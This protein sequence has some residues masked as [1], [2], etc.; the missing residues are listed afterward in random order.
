MQDLK[1]KNQKILFTTFGVVFGMVILA[2][3]SV[4]LYDLLC[5]QMG[6]GGTTRMVAS[7]QSEV[8]ERK[9]TVRFDSGVARNMPW[10]FA[11]DIRSVEVKIGQDGIV[12]FTAENPT[13]TPIVGTAVYN[14]TPLKA[15]KYF[16]KTQCFCFAEQRLNP[17]QRVHMPVT[18]YIDPKI[19]NDPEMDDVHTVTL[20]Y[21]F[22]RHDSKELEK[23]VEN[24]M[25][26]PDNPVN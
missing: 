21:T 5:R 3:A 4:P 9:M 13:S 22:F 7:N 6:W 17:G 15:G 10:K 12:A 16:Y 20:S 23:A 18:F 19:V 24:F 26:N 11:P 1:R 2:Y 8:I 14:V 25:N